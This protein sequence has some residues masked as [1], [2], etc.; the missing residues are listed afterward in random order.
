MCHTFRVNSTL[1]MIE[2]VYFAFFWDRHFQI[3]LNKSLATETLLAV[4]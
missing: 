2:N 1:E 3:F 4:R